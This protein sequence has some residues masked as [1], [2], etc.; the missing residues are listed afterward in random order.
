MLVVFIKIKVGTHM[1]LHVVFGAGLIGCYLGGV[2]QSLGL[3]TRLVCRENIQKKLVG[4]LK[5]TDY[6]GNETSVSQLD[7]I[8][9]QN[10]AADKNNKRIADFL[11]LTVKCTG[12]SRSIP[13]LAPLVGP[14]TI[15]LC[16]QNGLGS[17]QKIKQAFPDNQVLR[18]MVPFNVVELSPGH[19]HRGSEG[20]LSMESSSKSAD[21]TTALVKL[22]DSPIMP[23]TST[24]DMGSLL[25]AKLQLNLGNS[26][27]ALADIPVKS[28]LEQRGYRLVIAAMM[29]E[30][31]Q[32]TDRLE[33]I[34][35]KVTA[36]PAHWIPIILSLPNFMFKILANKMLAIDP[37]VRTSMW[38][39]LSQGKE[40]EIDYLNGA[41]LKQAELLNISCPV[42]EK[43][44]TLIKQL[45]NAEQNKSTVGLQRPVSATKLQ[46]LI[47]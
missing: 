14:E 30:L 39:D 33:I 6:S 8:D 47:D 32:I 31:L 28:M 29:K 3:N 38:W 45:S 35:P 41:I 20:R 25:W 7:F 42:N 37:T 36:L 17:E 2:L 12:V 21:I 43:I 13:D 9:P 27:N 19:L 40:T 34:L 44:V 11:W 5:L 24:Q 1:K 15:I 18:V 26:I 46:A 4:G 23:L 16:C 22:I 10:L